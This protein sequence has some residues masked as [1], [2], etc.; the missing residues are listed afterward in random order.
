MNRLRRAKVYLLGDHDYPEVVVSIPEHLLGDVPDLVRRA[1]ATNPAVPLDAI[2]ATVWR[3]GYNR[4]GQ[5]LLRGIP[6]RVRDEQ[7]DRAVDAAGGTSCRKSPS[8]NNP[9]RAAALR[10]ARPSGLPVARA[11][12]GRGVESRPITVS[13]SARRTSPKIMTLPHRVTAFVHARHCP[14]VSEGAQR[15]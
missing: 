12:V 1:R 15:T 10:P 6:M 9:Q 11:A 4:L 5:N 13:S 14:R 8:L 2:I 3:L 7:N